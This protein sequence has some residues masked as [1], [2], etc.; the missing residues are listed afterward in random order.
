MNSTEELDKLR[1]YMNIWIQIKCGAIINNFKPMH[2]FPTFHE[3]KDSYDCPVYSMS[4]P[5]LKDAD[6]QNVRNGKGINY[7]QGI[8]YYT[9]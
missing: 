1:E 3:F 5:H 9:K 4:I 6:N 2:Y 8:K 7:F